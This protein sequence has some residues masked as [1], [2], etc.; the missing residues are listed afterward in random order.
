VILERFEVAYQNTSFADYSNM[1]VRKVNKTR[2]IVGY[3]DIKVPFGNDITVEGL[4]YFKQGGEYRQMPY[5]MP[6]KGFC[7]FFG[8][9]PCNVEIIIKLLTVK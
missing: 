7:D 3:S 2:C 1:K 4:G 5:R 9:D 6:L 8:E